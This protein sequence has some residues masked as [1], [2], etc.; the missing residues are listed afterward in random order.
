MTDALS[1]SALCFSSLFTI[2]NPLSV[3]PAFVTMT[4]GVPAAER[5]RA[6][7]RAC[8]VALGVLV[9]FAV[10]GGMIFRVFGITIDAFRIAGGILFFVMS[11]KMLTGEA[12]DHAAP[13]PAAGDPAIVPLGMP[14]I[15]GP[16]AISTVMVLMGQS[17][18]ATQ[19]ISLLAAI[20]AAVGATAAVLVASPAVMRRLGKPGVELTTR[21][22]GLIVC[23]IGIQ[24]VIDGIRPVALGILSAAAR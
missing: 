11:M 17:G 21:V 19:V 20:V 14:L 22:M 7:I 12:R 23:V 9:V 3:A 6:A 10:G 1:F 15:C 13:G 18:S 24:F 16:G 2:I 5:R 8:A 4:E